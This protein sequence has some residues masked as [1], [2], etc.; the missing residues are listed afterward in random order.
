MKVGSGFDKKG[1]LQEFRS[2]L[3]FGPEGYGLLG[4]RWNRVVLEEV[5][6][7]DH[8]YD[9][10]VQSKKLKASFRE[11][12]QVINYYKRRHELLRAEWHRKTQ[13]LLTWDGAA[14]DKS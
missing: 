11:S 4:G 6:R 1:L 7:L 10:W 2:L 8:G 5:R 14:G 12:L 13:H 3:R 9:L